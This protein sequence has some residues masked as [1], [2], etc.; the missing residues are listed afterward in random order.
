MTCIYSATHRRWWAGEGWC[1]VSLRRAS[2]DTSS[3]RAAK[4]K[5][6]PRMDHRAGSLAFH[7][8]LN[9][10]LR[11]R[12]DACYSTETTSLSPPLAGRSRPGCD[13]ST[14]VPGSVLP[15]LTFLPPSG[16]AKSPAR[17]TSRYRPRPASRSRSRV[18]A[19]QLLLHSPGCAMPMLSI[20]FGP[21]VGNTEHL[22]VF[23]RASAAL[24]PCGDVVG[25]HLVKLVTSALVR[26]GPN[27]A[28]RAVG[29]ALRLGS[30]G[31]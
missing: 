27:R 4:Y 5:K 23:G 8:R 9:P 21:I 1:P 22:A 29:L 6:T 15:L 17:G 31:R 3:G 7:G 2:A 19:L 30:G 24:T 10:P 13:G 14:R 26:V 12:Q 11:S 28:Q 16:T 18:S 20:A 25:V